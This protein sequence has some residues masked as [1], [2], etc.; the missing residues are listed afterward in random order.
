MH[1]VTGLIADCWPYLL[2]RLRR[3]NHIPPVV[4]SNASGGGQAYTKCAFFRGLS[5]ASQRAAWLYQAFRVI[6]VVAYLRANPGLIPTLAATRAQPVAGR[7]DIRGDDPAATA[8]RMVDSTEHNSSERP[9]R[10]TASGTRGGNR[11]DTQDDR[12]PQGS[13]RHRLHAHHRRHHE[14]MLDAA[15]E[16]AVSKHGHEDTPELREML[17]AGLETAEPALA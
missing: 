11:H 1:S 14:E 5:A 12:L 7:R 3:C 9:V 17:R 2:Q 15:A 4:L 8:V 10:P 13:Q 6:A 16:H